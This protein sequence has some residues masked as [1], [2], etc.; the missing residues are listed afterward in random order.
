MNRTG[1]Q[2]S[3]NHRF[4]FR[5]REE[6]IGYDEASFWFSEYLVVQLNRARCRVH[7]VKLMLSHFPFFRGA[8][9]DEVWSATGSQG[10]DVSRLMLSFLLPVWAQFHSVISSVMVPKP[11]QKGW[12]RRKVHVLLKLA[13]FDV[14]V[15]CLLSALAH[16]VCWLY[17]FNHSLTA[18]AAILPWDLT[19]REGFCG[20][21]DRITQCSVPGTGYDNLKR[22]VSV[23]H[24]Q[25]SGDK[26]EHSR[27]ALGDPCQNLQL[28]MCCILNWACFDFNVCS[29][30]VIVYHGIVFFWWRSI[31]LL[32]PSTLRSTCVLTER[33]RTE[34]KTRWWISTGIVPRLLCAVQRV[35]TDGVKWMND[36][37]QRA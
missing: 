12:M 18:S 13:W 4:A 3:K 37:P 17:G 27:R 14:I 31:L 24:F 16:T 25:K 34:D 5:Q 19:D 36:K 6:R 20:L 33:Y 23:K 10:D 30:F 29:Q 21:M 8:H 32:V 1:S 35:K 22:E 28:V 9:S 2:T 26:E 7:S 15:C 11:T